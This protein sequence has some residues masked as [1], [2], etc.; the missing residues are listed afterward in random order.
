MNDQSLIIHS[1]F[2]DFI[3]RNSIQAVPPLQTLNLRSFPKIE[4]RNE[5]HCPPDAT[6]R[7][8]EETTCGLSPD[9]ATK[10]A[11]ERCFHCGVCIHCDTCL[12]VCPVGAITKIDGSYHI[13]RTKCT[14]CRLCQVE[15]PRNAIT[16]PATGVCVACGYCTTWFECPALVRDAE[17]FVEIDRRT[18]IDCGYCIQVCPQGA[19]RPMENAP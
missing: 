10:E 3:H 11:K 17:G 19:I 7:G 13:D 8:F 1:Y 4:R 5:I 18:C 15:C 14:G 2:S 9:N 16:M 6:I 12:L